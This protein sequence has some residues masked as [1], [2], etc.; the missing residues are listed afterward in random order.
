MQYL[1][2]LTKLREAG[3]TA[4]KCKRELTSIAESGET[5]L[6]QT[7]NVKAAYMRAEGDFRRLKDEAFDRI[8]ASEDPELL[9][10]LYHLYTT[11]S[12]WCEENGF[13]A[14]NVRNFRSLLAGYGQVD[15]RRPS[16]REEKTTVLLGYRLRDC[17][18]LLVGVC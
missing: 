7:A 4:E 13:H 5:E 18:E 3:Q 15:R 14:E 1:D 6:H 16:S 17:P 2:L 8:K 9:R 10:A 12:R 11:Y